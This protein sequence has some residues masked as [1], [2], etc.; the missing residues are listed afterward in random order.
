MDSIRFY[1]E[2][3]KPF[4]GDIYVPQW[5][6]NEDLNIVLGVKLDKETRRRFIKYCEDVG[7]G[8]EISILLRDY[9]YSFLEEEEE[10][11]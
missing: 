6:D 10:S 3:I 7:I 8:D 2:H 4:E 5:F 11:K 9:Y 1:K